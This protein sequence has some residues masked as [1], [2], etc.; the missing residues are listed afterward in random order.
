MKIKLGRA[1]VVILADA[2]NPSIVSP[3]WLKEKNLII[4]EPKQFVHTPDFSLFDSETFSL[5]VDRQRLQITVKKQNTDALEALANIGKGYIKLL[6]HIPYRALGLNFVWLAEANEK[7]HLP[8]INIIIDSINDVSSILPDHEL[9]YGCII[10]ASK[11]PYLLR[12]TIEPQAKSTLVYNF[13]YHHEVRGL[14]I[15]VVI[16][17]VDNFMNLYKDS[18]KV[19]EKI[20]FRR[21]KE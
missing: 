14:D 7:E 3:Q 12:L 19:V 6:P 20:Y 2:H 13:N 17:Y 18:Q 11:E 16:K 1:D 10:Y 21:G 4:E 8:K 5:I 15:N 9:N